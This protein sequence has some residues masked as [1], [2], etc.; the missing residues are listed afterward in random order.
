MLSCVGFAVGLGNVWRFPYLAYKN[1]GGA[2]LIPYAIF[3]VCGGVPIFFLEIALGQ[4]MSRGNF[5]AW[6]ICPIFQGIGI[7]TTVIVFLMN[8]YYI[9][10]LA[11]DVYYMVLAFNTTLPWSHCDNYWNTDRCAV[12]FEQLPL[13]NLSNPAFIATDTNL[14]RCVSANFSS[15]D[16][17]VE[18]WEN[19]VLEISSGV[20]QPNG[21]VWQL[22]VSLAVCWIM[23]YFCVWKGI[24]WTGKVVY[25]TATFPYVVLTILLI[26]GVTLEGAVDGIIFYLYP[27]FTRLTEAQVWID[28]GTQIFFSYAIGI[29]A[30]TA[31]GSYNKFHNNFYKDCIIISCI[32]SFTS[33]YAGFVVFSVLGFMAYQ[34]NTD[35]ANV[36]ESGPGLAFIAYPKAVT[37]MACAPLWAILF[38]L[39]IVM[40]GLDSQFVGVEAFVTVIMDFF[41][42][43]RK[44][45]NR[46]IFTAGYCFVSFLVGLSMVTRGGMYV[47]QLFDYYS[48]S[49]VTLLW[50]CFF[51]CIA[52]S[53]VYG[54]KRFYDNIE[55][56][57]G[58]RLNRWLLI[59]WTFITPFITVFVFVFMW[60]QF[61]PLTYNSTYEYPG[62]AQAIGMSFAFSSMVCIPGFFVIKMIITPG[63][64]KQRWRKCTTPS[65]SPDQVPPHWSDRHLYIKGGI[66]AEKAELTALNGQC[67]NEEGGEPA[68]PINVPQLACLYPNGDPDSL[69]NQNMGVCGI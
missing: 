68:V 10:I 40:L 5:A 25:F 27:D 8:A 49:G 19:K 63:S 23:V 44:G 28:A 7:A 36:A 15:V 4:F 58:F 35:I 45:R 22:V 34:Q 56:M 50:V 11:W 2:F 32:N 53:W 65:L 24:K 59:C 17:V 9:V 47:F 66:S 46:E 29:G 43:L 16:P 64:L 61:T 60:V 55:L 62:W 51:E 69:P 1:G 54:A 12:S 39:M 21:L 26:R 67:F 20:D 13:C 42:R 30:M 38:F 57:I 14:T 41:P 3:L 18:F 6:A 33:L 52:I 31:L 37:Q 48:A